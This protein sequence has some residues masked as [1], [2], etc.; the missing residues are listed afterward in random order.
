MLCGCTGP[1]QNTY[2]GPVPVPLPTSIVRFEEVSQKAGITWQRMHGGFG[3]KWMPETMGGGGAFIDVDNDGFV[4]ILL[5]N[6]DWWAGHPLTGKRPTLALY[7]NKGNGTF[8]DVTKQYGLDISL[9]GM[10]VAVGDF[11]NDGFDDI[12]ITCLGGNRLFHNEGGKRFKDV[13][14]QAGVRDGGWSTSAAWVDYD[15]DGRLDLFVCHYLKWTPATDLFCGTDHKVYCLPEKYNGESCRLFHNEGG[16]K[17]RDVTKEAGIWNDR[18]KGLGVCVTDLNGDGKP[19]IVVACDMMP[20][21]VLLNDGH[22]KF[23]QAGSEVGMALGENGGFHAGMGID[24]AYYTSDQTLGVAIG[25]FTNDGIFLYDL[26]PPAAR[27]ELNHRSG[28]QGPSIPYITF[29]VL[30]ADFDNDGFPDLFATNGHL[31]DTITPANGGEGYRQPALLLHNKGDGSFEDISRANPAIVEPIVGRGAARGDFDNDGKID[32]LLIPNIGPPRLLHN[33]TEKSGNWIGF[34]L[35]GTKS[36]A[37]GYGARVTIT[38]AGL[39]QTA[40]CRS[41]S[42]YLS[43]N[44]R[45]VHFGLSGTR[46]VEKVTVQWPSGVM[47]SWAAPAIGKYSKL[48][49]GTGKVE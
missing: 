45:R 34:L 32:L 1:S 13:T 28:L 38:S 17:F 47:E 41:G 6:G 20:N 8:T 44:D 7:R 18:G 4:D 33:T 31:D 5:I 39:K 26:H 23:R 22:G 40:E 25:N 10:G 36:N 27:A 16:G 21:Q 43:A 29:G 30:F 19:D 35:K 12:Y 14:D 2:S 3:Q 49:E 9:Q 42:S 37:D 15:G 24:S 46:D 11:D 48:V